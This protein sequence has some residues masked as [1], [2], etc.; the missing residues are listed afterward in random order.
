MAEERLLA[1]GKGGRRCQCFYVVV[2]RIASPFCSVA[3]GC[4]QQVM[5]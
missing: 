1:L 5:G 2:A 3:L 4:T